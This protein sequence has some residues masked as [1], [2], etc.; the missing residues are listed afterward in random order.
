MTTYTQRVRDSILP[1]SVADTLPN[2][3]GEWRFTGHTQ[4]HEEP[5]ETCQLCGQEGLRYHFEIQNDYT[6]HELDVGSH[7]ILQFN[8]PVYENGRQLTPSETKRHLNKLMQ[9]M[10]L[11]SCLRALEKLARSE[12]NDIL[13]GALDYYRRNKKLTPKQAFVVFWRLRHNRIDHDPSFF[14]V[15]LRKQRYRDDLGAMETNKVHFFWKALTPS[16]RQAAIELGHS[17][18]TD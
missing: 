7:C 16:Q 14:D 3:F 18:P 1:L 6:G 10:R 2:A 17:A 5:I 11:E 13:Q 12:N 15:T 4:D 8:V 9:Q